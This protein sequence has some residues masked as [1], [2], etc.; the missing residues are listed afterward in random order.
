MAPP[1][2]G[3]GEDGPQTWSRADKDRDSLCFLGYQREPGEGPGFGGQRQV[4]GPLALSLQCPCQM[5]ASCSPQSGAASEADPLGMPAVSRAGTR[6]WPSH[7]YSEMQNC[8][9]VE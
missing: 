8:F 4:R 6:Q 2:R 1:S 5:T 9:S 7:T 3:A